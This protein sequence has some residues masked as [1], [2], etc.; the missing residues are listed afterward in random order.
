MSAIIS[1]DRRKF[2]ASSGGLNFGDPFKTGF[3]KSFLVQRQAKCVMVM[4]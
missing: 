3:Y 4:Y 2:V 1:S